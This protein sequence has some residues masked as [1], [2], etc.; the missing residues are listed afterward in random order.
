MG[1]RRILLFCQSSQDGTYKLVSHSEFLQSRPGLKATYGVLQ[2]LAV[3]GGVTCPRI[4]TQS[5]CDN[6]TC[7]SAF[8]GAVV[9]SHG[10]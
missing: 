1:A 2:L 10:S 3:W 6:N 5:L 8:L 4:S 7:R 9:R